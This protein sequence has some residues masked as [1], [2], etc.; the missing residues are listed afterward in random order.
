VS[1]GWRTYRLQF[2]GHPRELGEPVLAETT[3]RAANIEGAIRQAGGAEWPPG[4]ISVLGL[5][6]ANRLALKYFLLAD[7]VDSI[8]SAI[9]RFTDADIDNMIGRLGH[10]LISDWTEE[11]QTSFV[12]VLVGNREL[13]RGSM[14]LQR[15]CCKMSRRLE[16]L[17]Y[18]VTS[19]DEKIVVIRK[20]RSIVKTRERYRRS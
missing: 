3:V 18:L 20:L 2:L 14:A 16:L 7:S 10:E 12:G 8:I 6:I 11:Y 4:A 13:L 17:D 19:F 9:L 5:P 1:L 15:F